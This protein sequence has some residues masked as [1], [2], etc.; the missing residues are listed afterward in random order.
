LQIANIEYNGNMLKPQDIVVLLKLVI[1][2]EEP[3]TYPGLAHDLSMS[4]SE[5]HAAIERAHQAQLF[6]LGARSINRQALAEFVVHGVRYAYPPVRGALT[7]GMP[8]GYAAPP[9]NRKIVAGDDPPPVWPDPKGTVRGYELSP[10][11]KSVPKAAAR[12]SKLYEILA[13]VDA[14]RDGKARERALAIN[15]LTKRITMRNDTTAA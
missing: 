8:T 9:L 5:V 12:D 4:A 13:L 15:E 1:Q 7:R 10:L 3:W 14:L 11:Y 2:G 6:N